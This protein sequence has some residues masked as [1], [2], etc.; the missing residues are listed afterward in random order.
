MMVTFLSK[1]PSAS[2]Q[3]AQAFSNLGQMAGEAIPQFLAGRQE[4][5]AYKKLFGEEAAGL[6]PELRKLNADYKLSGQQQAQK[7]AGEFK[8]DTRNYE[9]MKDA[10]GKKFADVWRASPTGARTDLEKGAFDAAV[11]GLD[12]D[13]LL[14][15]LPEKTSESQAKEVAGELP[16]P[17]LKVGEKQAPKNMKWPEMDK[18]PKGYTPKEWNAEKKTWRQENA[19]IFERNK[20]KVNVTERDALGIKKLTKLNQSQKLPEG[21][22]RFLLNP[23][24]GDFYGLAQV[25]GLASPE[26][27]EWIKEIARFQNRA[28]DSFGAKVTNFDLQSYMKQFPGLL[29]TPEGRSRIL[30]MMKINN[31]LDSLHERALNLIY[32]KYG[33]SGI[34]QEEAEKLAQSMITDETERLNNEFLELDNFN[35][36]ALSGK[37]V[38]VIGPDGTPYEIDESQ[39]DQLPEGFRIQ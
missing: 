19:P 4:N 29:N 39:I 34:P 7:L 35:R 28:K 31:E 24:T 27:Q 37:M 1:Q 14:Q 33:L 23:E 32:G 20:E 2:Q 26:A 13:E 22:E 38:D 18:R 10:F 25:A 17:Q 30:R 8:S 12:I 5:E 6:S 21:F 9:V 36:N 11:R 15:G 16:Q 3:F